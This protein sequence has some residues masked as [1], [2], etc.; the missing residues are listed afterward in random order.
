MTT[1]ERCVQIRDLIP[2]GQAG[3]G[4][5]RY[6]VRVYNDATLEGDPLAERVREFTGLEGGSS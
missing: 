5:F 1:E 4:D 3:W 6:E 2:A